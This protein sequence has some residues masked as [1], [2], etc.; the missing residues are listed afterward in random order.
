VGKRWWGRKEQNNKIPKIFP[1]YWISACGGFEWGAR[2]RYS[3]AP[4]CGGG[5]RLRKNRRE[6]FRGFVLRNAE[7]PLG[8]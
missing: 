3:G 1:T 7:S 5:K 8:S 4:P 2:H 6:N